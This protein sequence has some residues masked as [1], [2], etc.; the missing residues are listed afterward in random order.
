MILEDD[1]YKFQTEEWK[2]SSTSV[3]FPRI[4]S[5]NCL[6]E[7]SAIRSVLLLKSGSQIFVL[8]KMTR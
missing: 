3:M 2:P 6:V 7:I 8:L 5:A 1:Q 4:E